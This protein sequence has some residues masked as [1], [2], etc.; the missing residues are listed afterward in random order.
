MHY[1]GK[2]AEYRAFYP[3]G[4][5]ELLLSVHNYDYNWQIV[6]LYKKPKL[7]P[8]GTRVEVSIWYDNSPEMA[9]ERQ[10]DSTKTVTFGPESTDEMMM[11]F[12]MAAPVEE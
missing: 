6:Y 4:T 12:L 2:A 11:G 10:F 7:V 3:D 5:E 1:R 8:A 9:A